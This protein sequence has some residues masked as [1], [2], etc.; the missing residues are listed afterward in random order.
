MLPLHRAGAVGERG[1][2]PA[3]LGTRMATR[4]PSRWR[5]STSTGCARTGRGLPP[6]ESTGPRSRAEPGCSSAGWRPIGDTRPLVVLDA[7]GADH[8]RPAR[9]RR[10]RGRV[11]DARA[12][13]GRRLRA[14]AA[15]RA[16]RGGGRAR[17]VELAGGPHAAGAGGG[18]TRFPAAAARRHGAGWA[19]CSTWPRRPLDRV[20]AAVSAPGRGEVI[21]VLPAGVGEQPATPSF[22]VCGCHGFALR[23]RAPGS[24][25]LAATDGQRPR[26][27]PRGKAA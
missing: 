5:P 26:T 16:A 15:G 18:R 7:R 22:E 13:A 4:S 17:P 24:G 12:G 27:R 19:R 14:A 23:Q 3:R 9:R 11:A 8:E 1:T 6:R 21:L 20:P 25:R 2:R 10:T